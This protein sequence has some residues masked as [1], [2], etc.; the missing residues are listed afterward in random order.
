MSESAAPDAA[1]VKRGIQALPQEL[2][3]SILQ[4]ALLASLCERNPQQN[5]VVFI[6]CRYR[7]PWQL[8]I[9]RA[10]RRTVSNFYYTQTSFRYSVFFQPE[11]YS[12]DKAS[13]LIKAT[14][15]F[16]KWLKS[17]T[18]ARR[19]Q[20]TEVPF[21]ISPMPQPQRC[22]LLDVYGRNGDFA[23]HSGL[24]RV[25]TELLEHEGSSIHPSVLEGQW[26]AHSEDGDGVTG[27]ELWLS[28]HDTKVLESK[29]CKTSIVE[30]VAY[31][32]RSA[33]D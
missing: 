6:D 29:V 24:L 21:H 11:Y 19:G 4:F 26:I 27:A 22:E 14:S 23:I 13:A 5:A 9:N 30:P 20:I 16:G 15:I 32:D 31:T 25:L 33:V 28:V 2:Q 17:L 8:S 1:G 3:D 10:S 18:Q 7:T 12:Q